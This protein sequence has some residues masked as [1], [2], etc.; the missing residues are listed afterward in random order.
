MVVVTDE[1]REFLDLQDECLHLQ[2]ESARL[3][4]LIQFQADTLEGKE[5]TEHALKRQIGQQRRQLAVCRQENI[6]LGSLV[7]SLRSQLGLTGDSVV[8]GLSAAHALQSRRLKQVLPQQC[9]GIL[10][11][12]CK[13]MLSLSPCSTACLC[14]IK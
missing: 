14:S 10:K 5:D 13:V 2:Q 12:L 8:V 7:A 6:A 11:P 3:K 4:R 9:S 1:D